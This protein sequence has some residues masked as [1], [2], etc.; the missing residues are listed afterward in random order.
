MRNSESP[1]GVS[2]GHQV[3]SDRYYE[4]VDANPSLPPTDDSCHG[5]GKGS[6]VDVHHDY[7]PMDYDT[8]HLQI[9]GQSTRH[10]QGNRS[11]PHSPNLDARPAALL[12]DR[13]R[14]HSDEENYTK[15]HLSAQDN[16]ESDS[17]CISDSISAYENT[18]IG[19][20]PVPECRPSSLQV[21]KPKAAASPRIER[22]HWK[23]TS[24][25]PSK[26]TSPVSQSPVVGSNR[27]TD[28][29]NRD[30]GSP[31]LDHKQVLPFDYEKAVS[32]RV[33]FR[34]Q[35]QQVSPQVDKPREGDSMQCYENSRKA[36]A[37]LAHES[38]GQEYDN[39]SEIEQEVE[40]HAQR[41]PNVPKRAFPVRTHNRGTSNPPA[42]RLTER[43]DFAWRLDIPKTPP[44]TPPNR[45]KYIHS[46]RTDFSRL[47]TPAANRKRS[48]AKTV[49]E[50]HE[51]TSPSP[52]L[53]N[54]STSMTQ[55]TTKSRHLPVTPST[56][57]PCPDYVDE[58]YINT[59]LTSLT[60]PPKTT[61][62]STRAE[63]A[64]P[65][66]VDE[67]YVNTALSS[68]VDPAQDNEYYVN[69]PSS[70]S[71]SAQIKE[72]DL[73]YDYPDLRK[74]RIPVPFRRATKPAQFAKVHP[75][76][77]RGGKPAS[78]ES[79]E[80]KSRGR[81][82]LLPTDATERETSQPLRRTINTEE[83][84]VIEQSSV[85]MDD[86]DYINGYVNTECDRQLPSRRT[87]KAAKPDRQ[88]KRKK[89]SE[90]EDFEYDYPDLQRNLLF[91]FGKG[92]QSRPCQPLTKLPPRRGNANKI[93]SS[94]AG[95]SASSNAGSDTM[96]A[97]YEYVNA[98]SWWLKLSK[99]TSLQIKERRESDDESE[100]VKRKR[101]GLPPRSIFRPTQQ[102]QRPFSFTGS[103]LDLTRCRSNS[104]VA[105]SPAS[106]T[107]D[108]CYINWETIY[109][110]KEIS[111]LSAGGHTRYVPLRKG[112]V[113]TTSPDNTC[114]TKAVDLS[115][116]P[117][118]PPRTKVEVNSVKA[119][120]ST[121]G[122][123]WSISDREG[124]SL[125]PPIVPRSKKPSMKPKP[126]SVSVNHGSEHNSSSHKSKTTD[127]K[128][129][130]RPKP[131]IRPK[132]GVLR[133]S[134]STSSDSITERTGN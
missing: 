40:K 71:T 101:E 122:A 6:N 126:A 8:P 78:I 7:E 61:G 83:N 121:N 44:T 16:N 117:E 84:D 129:A 51:N 109:S 82:D 43:T 32:K 9:Q 89:D 76:D 70:N 46:E 75:N 105:M 116:R 104:Y 4:D 120:E 123:S 55:S 127:T 131:I 98:P 133:H 57:T 66:Y 56:S 119:E 111:S 103:G 58:D 132:P 60:S 54:R 20:I 115:K 3:L 19:P 34:K 77:S 87:G 13:S 48:P 95:Q 79:T 1:H 93:F 41:S 108:D 39:N 33:P 73:E 23:T 118:L 134:T 65:D 113:D 110:S 72:D 102:I 80:L 26:G 94:A 49:G 47:A 53:S 11:V 15:F 114:A 88:D 107:L 125:P 36:S 31:T 21:S 10:L 63:L 91:K 130:L 35:D 97:N 24:Q 5:N 37:K 30:V 28:Y 17:K 12:F 38:S 29:E 74:A 85:D 27:R 62:A 69:S 106:C 18:E 86:V 90:K 22:H 96:D 52:L 100:K 50:T 68:I 2:E 124:E 99:G 25:Q 64:C 67:D 81:L 128:P 14:R 112:S 92:Q 45:R 59:A 42:A